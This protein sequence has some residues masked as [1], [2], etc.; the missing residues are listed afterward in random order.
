VLSLT[1]VAA[2]LTSCGDDEQVDEER[3]ADDRAN[4]VVLMTDDQSTQSMRVLR[5]TRRLIGER[6]VAFARAFASF[7]LCCPSRASFFT[8]QYAHNNGVQGNDPKQDGGGYVNLNQ[9]RRTLASWMN[10]GG[11][12]TAHFGKWANAPGPHAPPG[13]DT[14]GMTFDRTTGYYD[15]RMRRP[16]GKPLAYGSRARSYHTDAMT[17]Q[18]TRFITRHA[19]E[20]DRPMFLSVA[21]LAPHGGFGRDDAAGRRCGVGGAHPAARHAT[22]FADAPLPRPRSFNEADVSDKPD[23]I[24]ATPRFSPVQIETIKT[25]YR[26]ELASLLSVD[27]SV[28]RI[29]RALRRAD[30]LRDTYLIFTSDQGAF[31]GEHRRTGGKNLPYEEATHVPLLIRGPGL[32]R[33]EVL[34]DPVANIDLARTILALSGVQRRPRVQRV[35]DGR[36]LVPLMKGRAAWPDRAVLIEGRQQ[37]TRGDDYQ[38]EVASYQGVRTKRYAYSEYYMQTVSGPSE[39]ARARIG[40]GELSARELYDL[41]TGPYE[42]RSLDREPRYREV[43]EKLGRALD[44]L[45]KCAGHECQLEVSLP[46]R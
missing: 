2:F 13:W 27:Q 26:C 10:A 22:A 8:G 46:P 39:G 18:A 9:P 38:W 36:S 12:E 35:M 17:R 43:R 15:Y 31:H 45:R 11:Y 23:S 21:Y 30:A 32:P 44:R 4:V 41:K 37:T 7:P 5:R 19:G 24:R 1:I 28:V 3:R 33:G 34:T 14:W 40:E 6:G 29:I 16:Q 25:K 20:G 42:L